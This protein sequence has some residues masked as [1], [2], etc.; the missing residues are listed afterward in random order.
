MAKTSNMA[1]AVSLQPWQQSNCYFRHS[2]FNSNFQTSISN[3]TN[4][5]IMD[6]VMA[7][8]ILATLKNSD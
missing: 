4:Y 7:I 2:C 3:I 1:P 6:F 8:S 5:V